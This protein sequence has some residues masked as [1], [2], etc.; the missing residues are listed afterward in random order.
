MLRYII[1][2]QPECHTRHNVPRWLISVA[3]V[4]KTDYLLKNT[5]EALPLSRTP[6]FSGPPE[7]SVNTRAC[8]SVSIMR[9]SPGSS[10]NTEMLPRAPQRTNTH[11]AFPHLTN[12]PHWYGREGGTAEISCSLVTGIST[13]ECRTETFRRMFVELVKR[14]NSLS[15]TQTDQKT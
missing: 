4:R 5:K 9:I 3:H 15:L 7:S 2:F 6:Y 13:D 1:S 14:N 12:V 10:L 8:S 11:I